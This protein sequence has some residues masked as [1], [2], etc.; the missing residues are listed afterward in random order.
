M[1]QSYTGIV[2]LFPNWP[3]ENEA[4]FKTLRAAGGFLVSSSIKKGVIQKVEIKSENDNELRIYNPWG[5]DA[6]IRVLTE[7]D[8]RIMKGNIIQVSMKKGQN[9]LME[10]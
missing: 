8:E 4:A 3:G 10:P 1:L 6:R 2:R 7:G 9:I 5:S